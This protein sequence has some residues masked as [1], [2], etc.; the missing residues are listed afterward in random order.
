MKKNL[1]K[2][3]ILYVAEVIYL[4]ISE[5]KSK[6]QNISNIDAMERFIGSPLY[7]KISSGKY[8]DDWFEE[9]KKIIILIIILEKKFLLK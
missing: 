6:E 4:A 9:L 5:I 2:P 7:E 1:A 3:Y 8:H